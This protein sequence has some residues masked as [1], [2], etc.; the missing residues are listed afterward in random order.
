MLVLFTDTDTDITP[1]MAEEYGY[2]LISMP[3][4]IDG[5]STY[6]YVDFEEFDAHA[7]YDTLRAGALP[8]TSAIS[9]ESY[10]QYFEPHFEAGNDILYVHFSRA[11]TA[12]FD[13]MDRA[14]AALLEK[15]PNVHFYEVDTKAITIGSLNIVLEIGQ[16]YKDGKS[17]EEILA[18]AK[19]EV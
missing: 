5:K 6:P 14:V 8:N 16:M 15:Y 10:R 3:Y 1:K 13:A 7:F 18:W 19:E 2:R 9:E 11:M 17:A 4:S 12:T